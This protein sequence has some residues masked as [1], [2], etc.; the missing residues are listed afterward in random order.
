MRYHQPGCVI[1]ISTLALPSCAVS[2][3]LSCLVRVWF[4][5]VARGVFRVVSRSGDALILDGL[6]GLLRVKGYMGN[7][8]RLFKSK[9]ILL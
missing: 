3:T 2:P 9:S 7:P 8:L 1:G 6:L 5:P 4:S